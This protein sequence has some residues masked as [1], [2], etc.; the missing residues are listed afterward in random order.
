MDASRPVRSDPPFLLRSY[1]L[2]LRPTAVEASRGALE[3]RMRLP[4][5]TLQLF[6]AEVV[7]IDQNDLD[8]PWLEVLPME[9]WDR[10]EV[11][12]TELIRRQPEARSAVLQ[13]LARST[14][15]VLQERSYA[16]VPKHHLLSANIKGYAALLCIGDRARLMDAQRWKGLVN[17]PESPESHRLL[18]S[19]QALYSSRKIA[20][21]AE[22]AF[23][24][25]ERLFHDHWR[26]IKDKEM[27]ARDLELAIGE[28]L[29]RANVGVVEVTQMN[30]D[31]GVDVIVYVP[32]DAPGHD[33]IYVQVK[34][35]QRRV[36]VR[37]VREL[38]G[39]VGRDRATAG[40][41][42]A[43]SGFTRGAKRE[44][45]LSHIKVK[46]YEAIQLATRVGQQTPIL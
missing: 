41:L 2:R 7:C 35:G 4:R 45:S 32:R 5:E 36:T 24:P 17:N 18:A 14:V 39:V 1:T 12:F 38:I 22:N 44:A 26:R 13:L 10:L 29:A 37:E 16:Y 20:S 28:I 15:W 31:G 43:S 19:L 25:L 23:E 8:V 34:S 33:I 42:V 9:A 27:R 21:S 40:M 6:G 11:R 3:Y 30:A 46:L